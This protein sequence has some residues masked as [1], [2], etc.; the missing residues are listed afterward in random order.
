MD[1]HQ[2]ATDLVLKAAQLQKYSREEFP[3]MAASKAIRFIDGNFRAQGWQGRSF[4][5]WTKNKTNT[6]ILI[7][8]GKLRRSIHADSSQGYARIYTNC[9]YARVHNRGFNGTVRVRSYY[10]G[11]YKAEKVPTGRFTKSG[12]ERTKTVHRMVGSTLVQAYTRHMNVPRRQFMPETI[13]DSPV[14]IAAIRRDV[15]KTF[16]NIFG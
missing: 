10:R 6:T 12:K 11:S 15:I 3:R 7:K 5:P 1:A 13:D 2:L 4:L 14:L 9:A 16:K 8:T